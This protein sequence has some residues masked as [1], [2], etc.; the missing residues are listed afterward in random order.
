MTKL[1][2]FHSSPLSLSLT[3]GNELISEGSNTHDPTRLEIKGC[4]LGCECK[5]VSGVICASW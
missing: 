3:Q 4:T 5:A 1:K 2:A